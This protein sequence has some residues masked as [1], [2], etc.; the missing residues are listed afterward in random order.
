MATFAGYL[1]VQSHG[2]IKVMMFIYSPPLLRLAP[3]VH[4]RI[5][6]QADGPVRSW[7][8]GGGIVLGKAVTQLWAGI[9]LAL[10]AGVKEA[11]ATAPVPGE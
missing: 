4:P 8:M 1:H 11:Q 6:G 2:L 7:G 5:T 3:Y 10:L 9:L